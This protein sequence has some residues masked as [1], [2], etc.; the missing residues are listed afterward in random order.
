[1]VLA[2][3]MAMA[4]A[5]LV[6]HNRIRA[7]EE[8][9]QMKCCCSTNPTCVATGCVSEYQGGFVVSRPSLSPTECSD[10]VGMKRVQVWYRLREWCVESRS[11]RSRKIRREAASSSSKNGVLHTT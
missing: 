10:G 9:G 2:M 11:S 4:V 8:E 7:A 1:M 6:K 5:G 3:A